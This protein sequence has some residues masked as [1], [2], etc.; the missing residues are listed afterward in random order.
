[1]PLTVYLPHV[2]AVCRVGTPGFHPG[3]TRPKTEQLFRVGKFPVHPGC[4]GQGNLGHT[5]QPIPDVPKGFPARYT[6]GSPQPK[7]DTGCRFRVAIVVAFVSVVTSGWMLRSG[8]RNI[9]MD[10]DVGVALAVH[11]RLPSYLDWIDG[12]SV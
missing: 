7:I 9:R 11:S 4:S 10:V 3:C 5:D 2:P 12:A 8:L 6:M 1:V